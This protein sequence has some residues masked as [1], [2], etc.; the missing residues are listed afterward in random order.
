MID[1]MA[2]EPKITTRETEILRYL[3]EGYSNKEVARRLDLSVRTVETHRL[4]LRRKTQTGR[5][6]E[7][8]KL[9]RAMGL[10]PVA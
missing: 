9:A 7:L 3:A 10:E 8:V 2:S 5:L 4:N 1:T 6:H